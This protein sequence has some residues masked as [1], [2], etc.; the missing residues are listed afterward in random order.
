MS[1]W[2]FGRPTGGQHNAQEPA[3]ADYPP[4]LTHGVGDEAWPAYEPQ[5]ADLGWQAQNAWPAASNGTAQDARPAEEGWPARDGR[6]SGNGVAEDPWA[7]NRARPA[8]QRWSPG[9]PE[10]AGDDWADDDWDD[11]GMAPYPITYERDDFAVLDPEPTAAPPQVPWEPWPPAP[12]PDAP[13]IPGTPGTTLRAPA[14]AV[15]EETAQEGTGTESWSGDDA[16]ERQPRDGRWRGGTGWDRRGTG[17]AAP[18]WPGAERGLPGEA[19]A[20]WAD[21]GGSRYAGRSHGRRWPILAG[22]VVT[23]AAVGAAAVLLTTGHPRG[24]G[25]GS[26]AAPPATP[27]R[28]PGKAQGAPATATPST[29]TG[30]LTITQAQGV[31]AGYTTA[32]NDANAE[33]S[34]TLLA[35]I[36]TGSSYAIDAALYQ[37][38]Q[39][40]GTAPFPAFAPAQATYYI[41]RDEPASGPRWFVVQVANAFSSAPHKVTSTEY[42][43]FTQSTPGGT[44]QNAIEPYLVP[45]ASTPQIAVGA[46]GLAAT[47]SLDAA[48]VAVA[49]GQLP[50]ATAASLDGT[51]TGQ[52][53][54]ANPGNLA[55][56]SDQKQWQGKLPGGQVTDAHTPAPGAD[57]QEFALQTTDGGALVFYA[58]A[59][60]VTLTPPAG[61]ALNLSVPGLY[62]PSQ[63]LSQAGVSYLE[64]FA[65]YDP[66]AGDGTPRVVADY[67]G[68]TGKN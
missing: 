66:P 8:D 23:G 67:S 31:L 62:S 9:A 45:G 2:D 51:G 28:T 26:S 53:A 10:S 60:E 61:S 27:G 40:A 37:M 48:S 49:P 59:A 25:A 11:D 12:Y 39:A 16:G 57:G 21:I 41:P 20:D 32:N 6:R 35:T 1:H 63:S 64:Q 18:G 46:D 4:D 55:D 13:E 58:D 19:P 14:G 33:H 3:D 65:T 22:I 34:D 7:A 52:A 42:L 5:P 30:P 56:L 29:T 47:V 17:P 43:L 44:W 68:I 54:I 36:E 50:S 15:P 24:Q 38:Q